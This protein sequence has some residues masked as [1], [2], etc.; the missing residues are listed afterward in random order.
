MLV[1]ETFSCCVEMETVKWLSWLTFWGR[2]CRF[3]CPSW[4]CRLIQEWLC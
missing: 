2:T 3:G 1:S 4:K